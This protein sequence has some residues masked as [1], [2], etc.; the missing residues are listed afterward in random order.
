MVDCCC[1]STTCYCCYCFLILC[2]LTHTDCMVRRNCVCSRSMTG[3]RFA[4]AHCMICQFVVHSILIL[5]RCARA[6]HLWLNVVWI[7]C[8]GDRWRTIGLWFHRIFGVVHVHGLFSGQWPIERSIITGHDVC[9]NVIRYVVVFKFKI[10]NYTCDLLWMAKKE[11]DFYQKTLNKFYLNS[12]LALTLIKMYRT[13]PMSTVWVFILLL[14]VTSLST[15]WMWLVVMMSRS[16]YCRFCDVQQKSLLPNSLLF[17]VVLAVLLFRQ[18]NKSL[19]FSTQISADVA[20][21]GKTM[22]CFGETVCLLL[23]VRIMMVELQTLDG[24]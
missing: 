18:H 1:L 5:I 13:S 23:F 16:I 19:Q 4:N 7:G 14:V 21:Q 9:I 15:R 17:V 10:L 8:G 20:R 12:M 2:R 24:Q 6:N 22:K 3:T 11:I